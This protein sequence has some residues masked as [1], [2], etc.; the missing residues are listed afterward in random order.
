[1]EADCFDRNR[2]GAGAG[3]ERS[4]EEVP[5]GPLAPGGEA[6]HGIGPIGDRKYEAQ[7]VVGGFAPIP[8]LDVS[9][10]PSPEDT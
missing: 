6:P 9:S 7:H 2:Q 3:R 4:G 10:T 5:R 8:A 1:M